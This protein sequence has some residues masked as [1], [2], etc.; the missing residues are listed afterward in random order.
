[1][2]SFRAQADALAYAANHP[3]QFVWTVDLV[4]GKQFKS[5]LV[6]SVSEFFAWYIIQPPYERHHYELIPEDVPLKAFFD[7]DI[8]AKELAKLSSNNSSPHEA[9]QSAFAELKSVLAELL[10]PECLHGSVTSSATTNKKGSVHF[11]APQAVFSS[12]KHLKHWV[13]STLLPRL[14]PDTQFIP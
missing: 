12:M 10:G 5:F 11:V 6:A 1:M 13:K 8:K 7:L 2:K 3:L 4:P 9:V 14:S